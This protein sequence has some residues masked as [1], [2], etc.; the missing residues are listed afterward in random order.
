MRGGTVRPLRIIVT[1]D[2][3]ER[4]RGALMLAGAQAALGG[5]TA[6]F[7]QLD[8][9]ALIRGAMDAP[10]DG[11]H[12]DAGLPTL[13]QLLEEAMAL[14]VEISVCQSGMALQGMT[15]ADLPEGVKVTGPVAFLQ[16]TTD[17]ARLLIA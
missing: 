8:S 12:R 5:A 10:R 1:T 15:V 7:L 2:D 17:E 3:A 11:A 6:V 13:A 16:A 9:V 14:G 4:M